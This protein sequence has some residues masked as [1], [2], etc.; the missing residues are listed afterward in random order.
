MKACQ[1]TEKN[2]WI[3]GATSGIG[4]AL[5]EALAEQGNNILASGRNLEALQELSKS[6]GCIDTMPLDFADPEQ[7]ARA[8]DLLRQHCDQLDV[9]VVNAGIC[10]YIDIDPRNPRL[11]LKRFQ[12]VFDINYH[13]A[14]KTID[15][16]LPLLQTGKLKRIVVIS[17]LSSLAPLP[18]AEAYGASKAA[19]E[20]SIEGLRPQLK[21]AGIEITLLRPGFVDTPLTQK[22][23]FPMP[24]LISDSEAAERI[25]EAVEK[26]VEELNFPRRLSFCIALLSAKPFNLLKRLAPKMIKKEDVF[27]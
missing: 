21:R 27:Q 6:Y 26:G 7:V 13:A 19:L 2:I 12:N 16:A 23:D 3:T 5:T 1:L 24:F 25:I 11:P 14:L 4:K 22:N 20:Y 17:S 10:K 8:E 15:M 9:V 18:R